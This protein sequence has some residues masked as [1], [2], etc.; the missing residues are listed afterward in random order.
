MRRPVFPAAPRINVV[1]VIAISPA[2]EGLLDAGLHASSILAPG[3]S[4][5]DRM[6]L[7]HACSSKN[8]GRSEA[9]AAI[10]VGMKAKDLWTPTDPLGEAL[11][12]LR[13]SGTFY[14]RSELTEPWAMEM[15]A[16][17]DCLMFH[18]VT[19]GRCWLEVDG[20]E[21]HLLQTGDFALVP[22]GAGHRLLSQ[23]GSPAP[24]LFDLPREL[25]SERYE[26]LR[27][28]GG[29]AAA[30]IVCGVVRF[31]HPAAQRLV[32]LL[33]RMISIEG[34]TAP[35]MEWIHGALRLMATEARELLPGGETVITRL[36]DILVVQAIRAWL[37]R[38]P[39]A[40]T[41]WLG[42]LRDKQIGRALALIHR[43]PARAWTVASLA[44]EVAMSRSALAARFTE[45]VGEPVMRY[46]ARWRMHLAL[47]RLKESDSSLG[48]VASRLGYQSE[49]AF[50]RAF[51][52]CIGISPGAVRNVSQRN[53][54]PLAAAPGKR[55]RAG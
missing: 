51:K 33:P 9:T 8:T 44:S 6:S 22:H 35:Q 17:E 16:L 20:A 7:N 13:M 25:I 34:S 2:N 41:G 38:D 14:C 30:T 43:D 21:P 39:A 28:G 48:E 1:A 3:W 4:S 24:G 53:F 10:L 5:N 40:Q 31:E 18:A 54:P 49:A 29:G 15:P 11:H 12:L 19:A 46:V 50:S 55:V 36:S 23:R 47:T 42:A 26:I 45:L 27:H 32:D 37:A 52:R